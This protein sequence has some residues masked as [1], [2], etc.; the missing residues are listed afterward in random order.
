MDKMARSDTP[1]RSDVDGDSVQCAARQGFF[2][3]TFVKFPIVG[4][5][6]I[7]GITQESHR[8]VDPG[9]DQAGMSGTADSRT[10]RET[11]MRQPEP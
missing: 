1:K 10:A 3:K 11:G 2:M 9:A 8:R 4:G 7:A 6:T 5:T